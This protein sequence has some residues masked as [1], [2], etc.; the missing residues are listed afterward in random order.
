M[1]EPRYI[2]IHGHFYQPPR[3]SPW[4]GIITSEPSAAPFPNWNERILSECYNA[5]AHAQIMEGTVVYVRNNYE[6]LSFNFGPTLCSWLQSHGKSAYRAIRRA[7]ELSRQRRDGHGNAIAQGYNHSILPLLDARGRELQIAWGIHDF[8]ARFGRLPE[9]MWLPEC[10]VDAETLAAVARA[11]IQFVM[12]GGDQGRFSRPGRD[13]GP[14]L[15]QRDDLKLAVLRFDRPL[16]GN[17]AFT[18]TMRD[19]AGFGRLLADSALELAPGQGLLVATDGETFGHHKRSGAAELARAIKL[20]E[21]HDSVIVTNCGEF[22]ATHPTTGSFEIDSPSAWSC[23]HGVERWR[24]DC[25]CRMERNT[26]QEWREPLRAA[27]DFVRSHCDMVYDRFAPPLVA[28]S[29]AALKEAARLFADSSAAVQE[30]FFTRHLA[31]DEAAR[32]QLMRLFEMERAA[33]AA[34]T[35]CAWFFDDFGGLEGRVALRW[36]ARAVELAAE[37]MP[38]IEP[39]VLQQLRAVCSNRHEIGDAATLYLSIKTREARGRM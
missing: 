1:T 19:G 23:A 10:A 18:D 3:E 6:A 29:W 14:F 9:G 24:S 27:M 12:L 26:R 13:S 11:G 34:L 38:S 20:L 16:S 4:T 7:D 32:E 15:W 35:S 30:E 2:I 39:E 17:I 33:H 36:A 28:D 5:N 22:V 25:G 8:A 21:A 37:L 31:K